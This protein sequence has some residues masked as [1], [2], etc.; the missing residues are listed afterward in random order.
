MHQVDWAARWRGLVADREEAAHKDGGHSDPHYWDRRAPTFA[1]STT[2]RTEQFLGVV[3]PFV[4]ARARV[5]IMLREGPVPHP[6][7]VLRDRIGA[8][9]LPP[10]PRFSDLFMVLIEL[11]IRP[12]VTFISYPVVNRYAS[13]DEAIA[14]SRP[15]F[16]EGWDELEGARRLAEMLVRDGDELTYDSGLSVSGIAHW[17]PRTS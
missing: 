5:F 17:Q 14:D 16:G 2:G 11:G 6:A 3:W 1:R 10:I 7:N 15:L 8:A 4:S 13:L 9:P 12:D